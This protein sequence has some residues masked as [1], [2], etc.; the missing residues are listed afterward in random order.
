M[1]KQGKKLFTIHRMFIFMNSKIE[2][3]DS[4]VTPISL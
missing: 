4:L 1:H 2:M 3:N